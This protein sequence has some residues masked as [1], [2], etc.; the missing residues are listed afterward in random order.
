LLSGE[1]KRR[2]RC[3]AAETHRR[4]REPNLVRCYSLR[5]H[6]DAGWKPDKEKRNHRLVVGPGL[7]RDD[8]WG[9][10]SDSIQVRNV[11]HVMFE[12]SLGGGVL[13]LGCDDVV[14]EAAGQFR[15]MVKA[16]GVGANAS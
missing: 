15:E 16:G 2:T 5:R 4:T 8:E 3:Q 14:G 7:R 9:E 11:S 1:S 6:A 13:A 10:R 12:L